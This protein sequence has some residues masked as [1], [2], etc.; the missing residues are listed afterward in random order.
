MYKHDGELQIHF[1][2]SYCKNKTIISL[3]D[4]QSCKSLSKHGILRYNRSYLSMY[5]E[6]ETFLNCSVL[7]YREL[8]DVAQ[9]KHFL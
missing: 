5:L 6:H 3:F 1:G 7:F 9:Y 8:H 2:L 4:K